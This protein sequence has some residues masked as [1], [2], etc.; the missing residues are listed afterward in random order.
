MDRS[1]LSSVVGEQQCKLVERDPQRPSEAWPMPRLRVVVSSLPPPY[2]RWIHTEDLGQT[3]L[4]EA[5]SLTPLCQ[6]KPFHDHPFV[7]IRPLD[8]Y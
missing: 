1:L 5:H 2:R 6:T 8:R 7:M 3:L 4:A